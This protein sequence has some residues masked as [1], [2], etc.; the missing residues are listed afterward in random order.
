MFY[1]TSTARASVKINVVEIIK[2]QFEF[3]VLHIAEGPE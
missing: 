2:R 3:A 1:D